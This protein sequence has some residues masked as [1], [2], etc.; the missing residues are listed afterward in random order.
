MITFAS[1]FAMGKARRWGKFSKC[2]AT[3]E[4]ELS[5][6]SLSLIKAYDLELYLTSNILV[7]NEYHV[8]KNEHENDACCM[9]HIHCTQI[10]SLFCLFFIFYIIIII[11]IIINYFE[12]VVVVIIIIIFIDPP[13]SS[14]FFRIHYC[15]KLKCSSK[16]VSSAYIV[17]IKLLQR[18][19]QGGRGR[20]GGNRA[21]LHHP[22]WVCTYVHLL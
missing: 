10:N 16:G 17:R 12:F 7:S 9:L 13:S 1:S 2:G 15:I 11:I 3:L 6:Y 8:T 4:D 14:S 20:L 22:S 18:G 5:L 19:A 21:L